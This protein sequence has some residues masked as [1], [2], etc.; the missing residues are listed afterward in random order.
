M[1]EVAL[2]LT[3]FEAETLFGFLASEFMSR[4]DD[5]WGAFGSSEVLALD[6]VQKKL[7]AQGSINGVKE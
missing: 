7:A 4:A 1:S 2:K 6:R 3:R 5:E